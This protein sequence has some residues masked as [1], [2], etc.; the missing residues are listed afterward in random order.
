MYDDVWY[1]D[2]DVYDVMCMC[3]CLFVVC[4]VVYVLYNVVCIVC[5]VGRCLD[6][7]PRNPLFFRVSSK[8]YWDLHG[9]AVVYV[10]E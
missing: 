5:I 4:I 2:D 7:T 10:N 1:D 9:G 6:V 3:L 8:G